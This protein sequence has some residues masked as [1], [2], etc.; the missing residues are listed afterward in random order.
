[1]P[2]SLAKQCDNYYSFYVIIQVL[3]AWKQ[4]HGLCLQQLL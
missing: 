4:K 1:M 2:K 3:E